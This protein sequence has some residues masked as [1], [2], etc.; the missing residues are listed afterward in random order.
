MI[1]GCS[2]A[3]TMSQPLTAASPSDIAS[4]IA[5]RTPAPVHRNA[6]GASTSPSARNAEAR[7]PV[8]ASFA[9]R[10]SNVVSIDGPS[11]GVAGDPT[12]LD[13]AVA[14]RS[15]SSASDADANV[16]PST[17]TT[18]VSS[19]ADSAGPKCGVAGPVTVRVASSS[20]VGVRAATP[21][22]VRGPAG[23]G[24]SSDTSWVPCG[25]AAAASMAT[26][27]SA[28]ASVSGSCVTRT[29]ATSR[30]A[31]SPAARARPGRGRD[32][33]SARRGAARA[34]PR[35]RGGVPGRR[36]RDAVHRG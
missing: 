3:R 7:G 6:A 10:P 33:P 12:A 30:R 17:S 20:T 9:A 21:R 35:R 19:A 11:V 28:S 26:R 31:R 25:T 13:A 27:R 1:A 5:P 15:R 8:G 34:R 23:S 14:A 32:A 29:V 36:R 24:S 18:A 2:L 4:A 22:T 16:S